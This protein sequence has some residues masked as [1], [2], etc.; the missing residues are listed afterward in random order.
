[1]SLSPANGPA[2][3]LSING[4]R[5]RLSCGK[6]F[7]YQVVAEMEQGGYLRR[8]WL[9]RH[10][11]IAVE[12]VERWEAAHAA[13]ESDLKTAVVNLRANGP[14]PRPQPAGTVPTAAELRAATRHAL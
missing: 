4:L 1:V 5:R 10:Q 3:W 8:I 11:R 7:A 12:S 13:Q 14:P 9:G 2:V 6:T